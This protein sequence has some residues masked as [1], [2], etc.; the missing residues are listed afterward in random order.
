MKKYFLPNILFI[1]SILI[2]ISLVFTSL[3]SMAGS[4]FSSSYTCSDTSKHCVSSGTRT[5]EGFVVARDCWEWAYSKICDYPSKNDCAQHARCY[6]LGQRD[7]L[8]RDSLGNCINIKKEFSCKRWSPTYIESETVRYSTADREGQEGLV[9]KGIPCIDGN[10]L[11][12]SYDMDAE[13]VS[14]VS[15]LGAL[16]QGKNTEAGFKIFEGV[17]RRC[18]KKGMDYSNCCQV[19]PKGW[20]KKLGSKCTKDEEVLSE[21]RQKNL[22]VPAGSEDIKSAGIKIGK[23]NHHCCWGNLL[24]K[25]IQVQARKQ[26]GMTFTSGNKPNCRGLTLEELGRVDFSKMDFSEVAADIHKKMALPDIGDVEARIKDSFKSITRFD[27]ETPAHPK[28][29]AAGV[30]RNLMGPTPEEKRLAAEALERERLTKIEAE[31]LAQLEH[32]RLERERL[33]TLERLEKERLASLERERLAGVERQR[34]RVIDQKRVAKQQ[35]INVTQI[36]YDRASTE[37]NRLNRLSETEKNPLV[38]NN[39]S[40]QA[41]GWY[42]PLLAA[43]HKLIK[44]KQELEQLK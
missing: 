19:F 10:C 20:G 40:R 32:E 13:M 37:Y 21:Q 25:T 41:S 16:A 14:S 27:K 1:I 15:Q 3:E 23:K 33:A 30:N 7:C 34:K 24:E 18:A 8:M 35:E 6:S 38:Q 28:N 44:L 11:D 4:R 17:G 26:L 5:V 36:E 29:R 43:H 2:V 31:R 12:K 22:C 42:I 9:C 39:L